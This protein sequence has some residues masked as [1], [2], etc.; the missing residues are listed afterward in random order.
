MPI[1]KETFNEFAARHGKYVNTLSRGIRIDNGDRFIF[2][3]GATSD[4]EWQHTEPPDD[5]ASA[6]W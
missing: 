5:D 6:R 1:I 3:D 2:I 4:G